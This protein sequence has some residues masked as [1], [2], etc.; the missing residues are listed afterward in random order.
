MFLTIPENLLTMEVNSFLRMVGNRTDLC[1]MEFSFF[2]TSLASSELSITKALSARA[3]ACGSNLKV[4]G[5]RA[6]VSSGGTAC[7][8]SEIGL[9]SL[10]SGDPKE[11]QFGGM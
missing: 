5:A 4:L 10:H 8:P 11:I 3:K 7:P 2:R 9:I 1:R 6:R